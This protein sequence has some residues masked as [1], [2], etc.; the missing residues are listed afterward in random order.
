LLAKVTARWLKPHDPF[1]RRHQILEGS[2]PR[3]KRKL[4]EAWI[5]IHKEDL[6]TDWRLAVSGQNPLPIKPLE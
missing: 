6:V 2:F 5:E 1:L 3:N 4:V